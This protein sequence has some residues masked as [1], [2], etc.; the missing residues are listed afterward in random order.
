MQKGQYMKLKSGTDIRGC[1]SPGEGRQP[2]LTRQA[3]EKI[4][5]AFAH[6][7]A[8]R[9]GTT[10]DK[11]TI[12]VGHDTRESG[13]SLARAF[14]RGLTAADCDVT[15]C[16]LCPTPAMIWS[17]ALGHADGAAM[18]TAG[19]YPWYENG[20]KL[21]GR[22]GGFTGEEI[23]EILRA[24]ETASPV[25]RLVTPFDM[26]SLYLEQ[27]RAM[28]CRRLDSDVQCPLLGLHVVVDAGGGIGALFAR[29]LEELGCE[30]TGSRG[31]E[32]DPFSPADFRAFDD[33]RVLK[34]MAR[35]VADNTADLGVILDADGDRAVFVDEKGR[36]L[37]GDRLIALISALLLREPGAT[38]V[39]DSVTSSGLQRFIT[40]WGG[41]HY[42]FKRG[43][44]NVIRE[45]VRLNQ[46]GIDCPLAM[47]TSGHAAFRDNHFIDDGMYLAAWLLC[48]ALIL[49]RDGET[50]Y[51]LIEELGEP[52]ERSELRL[53]ILEEDYHLAAQSAI[54]TILSNTLADAS[55]HLAPDNREGV[56]ILFDLSGGVGNAW[57]QLRLSVHDPVLA[58]C[59][60]S[61]VPGGVEH[62]LTQ[63]YAL[64]REEQEGVLDLMPLQQAIGQAE[65][66]E[67]K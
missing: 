37:S 39:T 34:E 11:L 28:V 19:H 8:R 45:A 20:F 62:M 25:V 24:A 22:D 36:T 16:G 58:L 6:L 46:E 41:E 55:W 1:A 42:R 29:F 27:L 12:A 63:L 40:E 43:Y 66:G 30:I 3:A 59:A 49:K 38:I 15:D 10:P 44:Q 65:E 5:Y 9:Q 67:E 48:E 18:V 26:A 56:R 51:S 4:G 54:E 35:T 13:S 53:P 7:L 21:S 47:E 17:A 32:H 64:L 33:P 23:E 31:L 2:L 61:E 57:F 60:E 14:I 50:L 52:V